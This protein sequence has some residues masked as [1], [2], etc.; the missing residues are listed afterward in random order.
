MSKNLVEI[1]R[2]YEDGKTVKSI[3]MSGTNDEYE[4]ELQSLVFSY[5][6]LGSTEDTLTA[7]K[8]SGLPSL[9][10]KQSEWAKELADLYFSVGYERALAITDPARIVEIRKYVGSNSL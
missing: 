6:K 2:K 3:L 5:L 7:F 8:F 1:I 4:E 10:M 9:N